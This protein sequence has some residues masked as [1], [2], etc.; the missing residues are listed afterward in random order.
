ME[1]KQLPPIRSFL[2]TFLLYVAILIAM[3]AG[4]KY[5]YYPNESAFLIIIDMLMLVSNFWRQKNKGYK[6]PEYTEEVDNDNTI[7]YG[8]TE[9]KGR[10]LFW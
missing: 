3:A 4:A 8:Y 5:V 1:D 10:E 7:T 2:G 6:A 9:E